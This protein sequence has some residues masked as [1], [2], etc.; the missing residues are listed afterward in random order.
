MKKIYFP[1]TFLLLIF[2]NSYADNSVA[3]VPI[4]WTAI[5]SEIQPTSGATASKD[6]C[7]AHSPTTVITTYQQINSKTGVTTLNGMNLR[8]ISYS[9][10]TKNDIYFYTVHGELSGEDNNKKW[11]VPITLYEQTLTGSSTIWAT[12]STPACKGIFIANPTF[13]SEQQ[14]V[15]ISPFFASLRKL[16][17]K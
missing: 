17:K 5:F 11:S 7:I 4:L 14:K 3:D 10:E 13:L 9:T 12:W 15:N 1:I 8:Y 2:A 6:Y 16:T